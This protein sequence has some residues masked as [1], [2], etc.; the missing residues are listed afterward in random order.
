[1]LPIVKV[2]NTTQRLWLYWKNYTDD[3]ELPEDFKDVK[4]ESFD[5]TQNCTF[6]KKYN[7]TEYDFHYWWSTLVGGDMVRSHYH[8]NFSSQ[9]GGGLGSMLVSDLSGGENETGPFVNMTLMYWEKNCSVFFVT[10]MNEDAQ[11]G[12]ELY[13]RNK[14]IKEGAVPPQNCTKYYK[15][16]CKNTTA[17]Y[18]PTCETQVADAYEELKGLIDTRNE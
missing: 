16:H 9:G 15:E 18:D 10:D 8:G 3:Y 6:I 12:C 7:I 14:A 17:V 13:V 5:L 4:M 11:T 1:M 2:F